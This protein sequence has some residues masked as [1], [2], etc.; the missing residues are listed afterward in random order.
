MD[1]DQLDYITTGRLTN[2]KKAVRWIVDDYF[3]TVGTAR[4]SLNIYHLEEAV[5]KF[6]DPYSDQKF[7][8]ELYVEAERRIRNAST[9][10]H[11][12]RIAHW[13]DPVVSA[14]RSRRVKQYAQHWIR[15]VL[16][17]YRPDLTPRTIPDILMKEIM[18]VNHEYKAN[19]HDFGLSAYEEL[20]LFF[21]RAT[22]AT[23]FVRVLEY[24]RK[25]EFMVVTQ[26]Q[27]IYRTHKYI[28]REN[29]G[30]TIIPK[31]NLWEIDH[32][33]ETA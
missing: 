5:K 25:F 26:E 22:G 12:R 11:Y 24:T 13:N 1:I 20:P 31:V 4:S 30:E 16:A 7:F 17:K 21:Q 23:R 19:A 18:D 8:D 33:R 14:A 15:G 3:Q 9:T 29:S 6:C 10:S 2:F 28:A 27:M 32:S